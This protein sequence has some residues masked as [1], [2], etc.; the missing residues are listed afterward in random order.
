MYSYIYIVKKDLKYYDYYY[1]N[2]GS[3]L[4]QLGIMV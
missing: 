2:N 4:L 3:I 1:V